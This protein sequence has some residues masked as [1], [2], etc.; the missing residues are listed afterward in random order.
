M[1]ARAAKLAHSPRRI[2]RDAGSR[3]GSLS[4]YNPPFANSLEQQTRERTLSQDR[5]ADLAANDWA[6]HSGVN[7]ITIN[8]V[9]TGLRPQS[10]INAKRL[11][12]S[13]DDAL[14]LQEDI[15][16]AWR[17]WTP[18][19]HTRGMLHF[20]D[21]QFLG[22][23]SMLRVGEMFHLPVML[24]DPARAIQL[25]IQDVL[26]GRLRTPMDKRSDPSIVDG[27]EVNGFGAPEG[28]WLAT[29]PPMLSHFMDMSGLASTHFTRIPARV[30]HRP[31]A[32]HLFRHGEEEQVRGESILSSG[33]NLFRNLSDALDNELVAAVT[34][35]SLPVF[36]AR[37]PGASIVP[38]YAEEK[39]DE[40]GQRRFYEEARPGT[41]LYGNPNEKPH[42]LESSRPSPNFAVFSEFVLRAMA[43][44]IDMPYEVLAKDYSKT[45]Y[46][47]ARAALLEA[48]RVFLLYRSWL[49][50][51]YCQPV[52]GMVIE[53]NWLAGRIKFPAKAPDFYD[54]RLLYTNALWIGPPRG[55]V[56]PVK[57]IAATVTALE[58]RLT[59]YSAALAETGRDFAEVMDER[60]E[61]EARM[62]KFTTAPMKPSTYKEPANANA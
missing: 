20:E 51:H 48:W 3:R 45:N 6:A 18:Q 8:S 13:P 49:V 55:Y 33:M 50:R 43:A 7:A 56:D 26:P 23:R 62:A 11:G 32:F 37:E 5:S 19:A 34:T 42:V 46:S 47:S 59:T 35:A 2:S 53:E 29:P 39:E 9:G 54:A 16:V 27:V 58:N 40:D 60:E 52:F 1:V 4:A 61:E 14:Q 25:A 17:E 38:P 21:L 36:I 28:Y 10:R 30:G 44:S 15:E 24:S 12:V 57:E 31:G 22:L 41:V